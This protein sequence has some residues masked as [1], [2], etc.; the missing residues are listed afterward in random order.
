LRHLRAACPREPEFMQLET[1]TG[2]WT[3]W[4]PFSHGLIGDMGVHPCR[5][6]FVSFSGTTS[7]AVP[8]PR[9]CLIGSL[10]IARLSQCLSFGKSRGLPTRV[11]KEP[12]R[13]SCM[14]RWKL[15]NCTLKNEK[16]L[17]SGSAYPRGSDFVFEW[18]YSCANCSF[19]CPNGGRRAALAIRRP[20]RRNGRS[21]RT[22]KLNACEPH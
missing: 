13:S 19:S 21:D 20:G 6:Q 18:Q 9:V 16:R 11:L 14:R 3:F 10:N 17:E 22:Q 15:F 2:A 4:T 8:I 7:T 5:T 12:G 1:F